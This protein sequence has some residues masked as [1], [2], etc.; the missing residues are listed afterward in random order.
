MIVLVRDGRD[1]VDS[2][3]AKHTPDSWSIRLGGE[4]LPLDTQE[5]RRRMISYYSSGWKWTI[6]NIQKAFEKH[7]SKLR[8]FV[9]YEDLIKNTFFELKKIYD[10]LK[11]P[12][13]ENE[14]RHAIEKYDFKN[15]PASMKGSGKFYRVAT[16]GKWKDNFNQEEKNLMNS[17]MGET[18]KKMN[19]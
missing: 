10:F 18:L 9:R 5:K 15:I 4:F 7:N 1:V 19:Y 11:M 8:Y 14:I 3:L 17:I 2:K 6:I 16:P 12:I 13:D